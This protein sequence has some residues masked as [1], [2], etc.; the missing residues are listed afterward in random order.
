VKTLQSY[1][2]FDLSFIHKIIFSS[3]GDANSPRFA[4]L[5]ILLYIVFSPMQERKEPVG[6]LG[7]FL[8][9]LSAK[10]RL[11]A[12]MVRI[13]NGSN[14]SGMAEGLYRLNPRILSPNLDLYLHLKVREA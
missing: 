2:L 8:M 3:P 4:Q 14:R 5:M 6:R 10:G 7:V 12:A 11:N 1:Y 13:T 9:Q